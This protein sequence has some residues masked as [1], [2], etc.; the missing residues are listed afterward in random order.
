MSR[1]IPK[2]K[3]NPFTIRDNHTRMQHPPSSSQVSTPAWQSAIKM[4]P[5]APYHP[6][7]VVPKEVGQF[8]ESLQHTLLRDASLAHRKIPHR[9]YTKKDHR[10]VIKT[11]TRAPRYYYTPPAIEYP[12][13]ELRKDFYVGHPFELS[14]PRIMLEDPSTM[15]E[16]IVKDVELDTSPELSGESVIRH[17]LYLMSHPKSPMPRAEA[18]KEALRLFYSRRAKEDVHAQQKR[19][20][21][22]EAAWRTPGSD[23]TDRSGGR[24]WTAITIKEEEDALAATNAYMTLK[25]QEKAEN[26]KSSRQMTM[27]DNIESAIPRTKR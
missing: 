26:L 14:R 9:N 19:A 16:E 21:K 1:Y 5:P 4:H 23:K 18:Y 12:E 17:A 3:Y 20:I 24:P 11:N 10:T 2:P 25:N 8:I 27:F 13:D 15:E 22:I 7:G 6:R